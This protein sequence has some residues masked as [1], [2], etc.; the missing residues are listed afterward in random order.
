MA[1]IAVDCELTEGTRAVNDSSMRRTKWWITVL[2]L[3]CSPRPEPIVPS[4]DPIALP[5]DT[6]TATE[7]AVEAPIVRRDSIRAALFVEQGRS[8]I[9]T[10]R[11]RFALRSFEAAIVVDSLAA[12]AY[13]ELARAYQDLAR[14]E[15]ALSA[16]D[17]LSRIDPDYPE[18]EQR[19]QI[20]QMR[21]DRALRLA[22][23]PLGEHPADREEEPRPGTRIRIAAVGDIQL[24]QAWPEDAARLPPNGAAE[25]LAQVSPLLRAADITFGNLETVLAD[26][27][28]STKCRS[29]SRNCYAFRVPTS[30]ARDLRESGFD[31]LSVNNNHA[32]DFQEAGRVATVRALNA[33]GIDHSGPASGIASWETLGLRIAMLAFSTGDGPYR[34]QQIAAAADSVR[35]VKSTHDLVIVSFHGGAEG[36]G[37]THV[38]KQVEQAYGENRGDVYS[39]ARAM[40]DAGSDLVLGHGPH[41]LRGAEIYRGRLIAYSLGNFSSWHGFNL[42]GPLGISVVLYATLA[43]NGVLLEAE[44]APLV[45]VRP[46]IPTPDPDRQA[47]DIIR[48]LSG[49]DFGSA[50]FDVN[51]S[52]RRSSDP[53]N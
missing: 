18:L 49:S 41:V 31:V 6:A 37:A 29:G 32:G 48:Q 13:R 23:T 47:I 5:R 40:V 9:N 45:L 2:V 12:D 34:I 25:V 16:L 38:P 46:G 26:S 10:L 15:D 4:P 30:F 28:A 33:V 42:R 19:V 17:R 36:A 1:L 44:L 11:Y 27:G 22:A 20:L 53:N 39:F 7:A 14:W 43:L 8:A 21:R 35:R 3:A 24:G 51:G 52:Y 50:L